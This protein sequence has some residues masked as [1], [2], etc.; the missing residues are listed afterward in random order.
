MTTSKRTCAAITERE[1]NLGA[2][3][4]MIASASRIDHVSKPSASPSANALLVPLTSL[5]RAP[6]R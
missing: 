6:S 1:N 2:T 4:S 3:P 5:R